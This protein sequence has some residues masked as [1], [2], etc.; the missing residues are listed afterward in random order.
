MEHC[1]HSS[2]AHKI[3]TILSRRVLCETVGAAALQPDASRS[4]GEFLRFIDVK[5]SW[6]IFNFLDVSEL[7][8]Y[9]IQASN[10]GQKSFFFFFFFVFFVGNISDDYSGRG[11]LDCSSGSQLFQ[12]CGKSEQQRKVFNQTSLW[13]NQTIEKLVAGL[14]HQPGTTA[15]APHV[16]ISLW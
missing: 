5:T 11:W 12:R 8:W 16:A 2:S 14:D 1:F 6:K 15:P 4:H 9:F 10:P 7:I 3:Q 13:S